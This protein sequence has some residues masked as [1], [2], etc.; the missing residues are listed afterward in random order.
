MSEFHLRIR[1]MINDLQN[2]QPLLT[3]VIEFVNEVRIRGNYVVHVEFLDEIFSGSFYL[4][5][6][7]NKDFP[8]SIPVVKELGRRIRQ[9]NYGGHIYSDR[10]LCLEVPTRIQIELERNPSLLYFSE[11]FIQPYL[12]GFLYHQKYEQFPF[13]EYQHGEIGLLEYYCTVFKVNEKSAAWK[14]L[15]MLFYTDY[16]GHRDCPCGSE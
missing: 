4:E 7:I 3:D 2:D 16:K 1:G 9:K 8:Q 13:G 15:G 12:F 5:I 14:L 6:I 10:S 11:T